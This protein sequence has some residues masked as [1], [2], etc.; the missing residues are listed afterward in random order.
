MIRLFIFSLLA[1]VL[2][3]W[4]TLYVGFP[5][6]PGYLL[7]AFG[8][9]TF[10]TSLF[11]LLVAAIV[12]YTAGRILLLLFQWI[13]P[14]KLLAAGREFNYQRK[15]NARS[16][17]TEGLLCI[18]RGNWESSLKL[19]RKGMTEKDATVV[20][21]LAG[22]YAA[23]KLGQ[24]DTWVELLESAEQSYP[25]ARSTINYVKAQLHYQSGQLEQS[26]AV[27]EE[28]KKNALNDGNLLGL[29]KEVY[30]QLDDWQHLEEL[31]PSLEKN[32]LLDN[33]DL[34]RVR[35]R[36]FMEKLYA[37]RN[38]VKS[39]GSNAMNEMKTLWKKAPVTFHAD[40][41]VVSHYADMLI[42]LDENQDAAKAIETALGKDWNS[43]LVK[44]YG[45]KEYG[46]SA[47][48][49]LV[50]E[51]WLKANPADAELLLS[52]GRISMRNQLWGKAKEY[53]EA[54]IKIA[55]SAEAYGELGRLM[56]HLGDIEAS[57]NYLKS[58]GDLMGA[59]LPELPMPTPD[60]VTH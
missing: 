25:N 8:N 60:Q 39:G 14:M 17:T 59:T 32:K 34:D 3:L 30:V 15:A 49:L 51:S 10:E 11:A 43:N 2:A 13:N 52:L 35:K 19:L 28:L 18:A 40:E 45:E 4:V 33:E 54:S 7:I 47:Q 44:L 24:R 16:N 9:V 57:E 41:K 5:A 29:L 27:L 12:I 46:T 31:L 1:I 56:K 50:A 21:Y 36:I 6:D 37:L 38:D 53:Y 26:L 58:Y 42:Q 23:Y 48:Q 55:P 20:N 22:A